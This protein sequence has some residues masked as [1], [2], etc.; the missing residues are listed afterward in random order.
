MPAHRNNITA[1]H[2]PFHIQ[3][4]VTGH[5]DL[6]FTDQLE[7][8]INDALITEI[9]NLLN[10]GEKYNTPLTYSILSPLAEGADRFVAKQAIKLLDAKLQVVLPM[11]EDEYLMDFTSQ[12]SRLEFKN[13]LKQAENC[14]QLITKPLAEVYPGKDDAEQRIRA[15]EKTGRYVVDNCD[16]LIAIWDGEPAKSSAGTGAVVE[17]AKRK[18]KPLIIISAND[19]TKIEVIN[20]NG[21]I[22]AM[23]KKFGQFNAF[24]MS[25]GEQASQIQKLNESIFSADQ[26]NLPHPKNIEFTQQ[27]L[28]PWFVKADVI[29]LKSQQMYRKVGLL[30]YVLSPAAVALVAMGILFSGVSWVFFSLEFLI[31]LFA[32]CAISLSDRAKLH[33]KWIESRYLAEHIRC[34]IYFAACGFKPEFIK[35][36]MQLRQQ[37]QPDN[38]AAKMFNEII[39][40]LPAL[41]VYKHAD[42]RAGAGFIKTCWI[43]DQLS[44]HKSKEI[45]TGKKGRR[46]E[47]AGKIVFFTALVSAL[48][49][50]LL[51]INQHEGKPSLAAAITTFIAISFPAVGASLGAI[52]IHREYSRLEKQSAEMVHHL[53]IL[54]EE[55]EDIS[56]QQEFSKFLVRIQEKMLRDV[57][58]WHTLME[59]IKIESV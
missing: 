54:K 52:R 33:K 24:E 57:Q 7:K 50:I 22:S 13:M 34:A 16:I 23:L 1:S 42:T 18:H 21:I 3:I 26:T 17:H 47:L 35:N 59:L 37:H 28:M 5:R 10:W 14:H 12:E 53:E 41:P 25:A 11:N 30:I 56:S 27:F 9:K 32:Y 39:K 4:G 19:P 15:Y 55:S 29:A 51:A 49:H 44:F 48:T 40:D 43:E 46:L 45:R 38:W 31:L 2:I 20:G 6:V 58:G 36:T 8:S